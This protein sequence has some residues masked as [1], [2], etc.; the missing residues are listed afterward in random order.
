[1]SLPL[2]C[3]A[4]P[5]GAET[6]ATAN[7]LWI[8]VDR[9]TEAVLPKVVAWRRDIHQNPELGNREVRTG[10]LVAAHLK[11]LGLEVRTG[12]AHTGVIGVLRGG[13][14]GPV[15][16]L[17]ADM[18]ALPVTEDVDVPFRST[19]KAQW[20]GKEVGVMHAC[21]HDN[22]TAILMGVAEVLAGLKAQLPGT[23]KFLFQ[24]AEEGV[25]PGEDGGAKMLIAEGALENPKVDAVFGL[26]VFPYEAGSIVYKPEG[27]MAAS[28]GLEITVHGRQTHGAL[29]WEGVD[30][31][32]VSSQIV[33]GLQTIISRQADLTKAPAIVTL[34]IIQGGNRSNIIPEE[35]K[36]TGTI[37]SFDPAMRLEIHERIKRTAENIAE[38]AGA[39][40]TV[41]I[42]FENVVTHNDPALTQRM[43]PTLQRVAGAEHWNPN[44]RVTTTAEDFADYQQKVPGIFFFL[45]ITPKGADP[46]T[47]A[48]NHS[49][50]FFAD[51]AALPVGVRALSNL[52][53]DYLSGGK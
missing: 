37:R 5:M 19:V 13:K 44:G 20:A 1:M 39:T 50:R 33:L 40:A 7:P 12:V 21:G 46:K 23:V 25:P 48:P 4:M 53:V 2:L 42:E 24:P 38:A 3:F 26:H 8:E 16:A 6:R 52:A 43:G 15:V 17:R 10:A 34:G 47:V 32:V 9:R 18:D 41:K 28:D 11:T 14:P 49:P 51:E 35:V 22:H 30:P 27:I 45:G 31:I 29:P 36:M